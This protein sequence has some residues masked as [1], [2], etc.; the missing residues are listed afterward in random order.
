MS[1]EN[2][3]K[4]S[5]LHWI[6]PFAVPMIVVLIILFNFLVRSNRSA[7]EAVAD[8]ILRSTQRYTDSLGD[9]L[10]LIG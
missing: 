8:S 3:N 5:V 4:P 7:K 6:L 1:M 9:E 2:Q 10:R